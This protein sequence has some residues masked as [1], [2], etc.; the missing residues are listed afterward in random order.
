M[1]G[2]RSSRRLGPDLQ[3]GQIFDSRIPNL[4]V[5][6][7]RI[8]GFAFHMKKKPDLIIEYIQKTTSEKTIPKF[9]KG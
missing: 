2:C 4:M 5:I 6:L 7:V 1:W 3:L 9:N 8:E